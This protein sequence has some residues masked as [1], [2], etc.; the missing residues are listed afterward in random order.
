MYT[1]EELPSYKVPIVGKLYGET[2]SPSAIQDKFYKNVVIMAEHEQSIKGMQKRKEHEA[3]REYRQENP[4]ARYWAQANEIE[5]QVSFLN[6][7]RKNLIEHGASQERLEKN[8]DQKTM[9][10]KRFNDKVRAI[11]RQQVP[12]ETEDQ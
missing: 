10:M 5:N 12:A 7:V 4:D 9:I 1:G 8:R 2:E 11:Q 3:L 6:K